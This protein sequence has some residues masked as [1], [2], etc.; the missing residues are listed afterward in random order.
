MAWAE[1][2]GVNRKMIADGVMERVRIATRGS[3]LALRQAN[4][5][6]ADLRASLPGLAVELVTISTT[7]DRN[8]ADA[9][10]TLGDGVFVRSVEVALLDGRA[11][12]A[13]HSAK[14]IPTSETDEPERLVLA[15]FPTR[16]DPRDVLISGI[17]ADFASLPPDARLGTGSP[18]RAAVAKHL[19]GD[20]EVTLIRGNVDTRLRKLGEGEYDAIVL[21]AAGL[22]RLNLL[23][24]VSEYLD[25]AVWIPA[26]GQGI[27]AVQCLRGSPIEQLLAPL[28]DASARAAITAERAVLRTLG[29][30]CRTPVGA[31][32][33]VEGSRLWLRGML[34]S[35]DGSRREVAEQRGSITDAEALGCSLARALIGAADFYDAGTATP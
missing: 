28:D 24:R 29:T 21:A 2:S 11:E 13:V 8:R 16:A 15:A 18:R 6:A 7:G 17:G 34:L 19:R 33:M 32:A 23:D 22:A 31:Y 4:M 10:S 12:I 26:P 30:G 1:G 25:P 27:L 14:D 3:A 35:P 20:L 9:I 5:I